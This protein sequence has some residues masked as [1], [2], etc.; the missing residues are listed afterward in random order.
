MSSILWRP[1]PRAHSCPAQ[2]PLLL[3]NRHILM[4]PCFHCLLTQWLYRFRGIMK[5]GFTNVQNSQTPPA[6]P[7]G[8]DGAQA[9]LKEL[10][11]WTEE[12]Y[13]ILDRMW[14]AGEEIE[15]IAARLDRGYASISVKAHRRGLPMRKNRPRDLQFKPLMDVNVIFSKADAAIITPLKL[16]LPKCKGPCAKPFRPAHN[17]QR[18]CNKCRELI[19]QMAL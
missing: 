1:S 2:N 6:S 3:F 11:R 7:A 9:K 19:R 8:D 18:I 15:I 16:D 13:A 12:E 10:K 17:M 4:V 14:M 5:S